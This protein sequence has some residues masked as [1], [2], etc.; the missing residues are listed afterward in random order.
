MRIDGCERGQMTTQTHAFSITQTHEGRPNA[1][2]QMLP[3]DGRSSSYP[4]SFRAS[5]ISPTDP[6]PWSSIPSGRL[7]AT[8]DCCCLREVRESN[9]RPRAATGTGNAEEASG[10]LHDAGPLSQGQ[11]TARSVGKRN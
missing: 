4:H 8:P 6:A 3:R 2:Q 1:K 7:C 11:G 10:R 5:A 9:R